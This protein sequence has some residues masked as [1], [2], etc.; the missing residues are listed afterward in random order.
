MS[1]KE[2]EMAENESWSYIVKDCDC[3]NEKCAF[4]LPGETN[5]EEFE[6]MAM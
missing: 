4:N 6:I 3:Q 5:H 1:V 2:S